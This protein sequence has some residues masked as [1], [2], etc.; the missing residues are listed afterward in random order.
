M[1]KSGLPKFLLAMFAPKRRWEYVTKPASTLAVF[2]LIYV[3]AEVLVFG[4]EPA[5]LPRR[6]ALV[7]AIQLPFTAVAFI[8]VHYLDNLQSNL[9][10]LAMTDVLTGLPNRRAFIERVRIFQKRGVV[11]FLLIIDADHFKRIN[12]TY[13]HAVGDACLQ[14]IANRLDDVT[15]THDYIGRIGGEEFAV[16]LAH[17]TRENL[18]LV[19]RQLCQEIRVPLTSQSHVLRFTLSVGACETKP[20]EGIET[21]LARAD[22]ALYVAKDTGR[23][24]LVVWSRSMRDAA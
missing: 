13:G 22:E 6:M 2:V 9:A 15:D 8:L 16:Y 3:A 20:R 11:G 7:L 10:N 17:S 24:R 21:A 12:D 23:A 5:N 4:W 1:S 18:Q 14:A 19:G